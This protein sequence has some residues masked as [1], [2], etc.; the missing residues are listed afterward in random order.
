MQKAIKNL[1]RRRKLASEGQ[2]WLQKP[3]K[4]K[5]SFGRPKIGFRRPKLA[6]EASEAKISFRRPKIGLKIG[7]RRPKL[8]S[9]AQISFRRPKIGFRRPELASEGPNW[10]R[11][12]PS[13]PQKAT[14]KEP[15]KAPG[16]FQTAPK[17]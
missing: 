16:G 5:I 2:N 12:L 8:A 3:Q 14:S 6:S 1:S 13:E 11:K 15:E 10:Q 7:F 17:C 9:E 4:P